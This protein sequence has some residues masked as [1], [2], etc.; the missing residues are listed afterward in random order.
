M[1]DLL[2]T[3]QVLDLLK[4]NR[5][6][7][8]RMLQDGRLKGVKIGQQ[9]R[10]LRGA[11]E[12]LV[13]REPQE[14]GSS[15]QPGAVPSFPTH[16]V[17]T[18]QDLFSG[19]GELSARVVDGAGEPLTQVSQPCRFCELIS[20]SAS[21]QRACQASWQALTCQADPAEKV[22][23]CHAGLQYVC[24][25]LHSGSQLVGWFLVGQFYWEAPKLPEQAAHL[26]RLAATHGLDER[27]LEQAAATIPCIPAAKQVRLKT[28]P[29]AAARAVHSIMNER[30]AFTDRLQQ[31]ANLTQFS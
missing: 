31:I 14:E 25:G 16:C 20:A 11:V 21:G 7:V 19:V 27:A 13:N 6:T 3:Q 24:A 5:I 4:I 9:W 2:T 26:K 18:L 1:D 28:W 10:F 12:R 15:L 22:F 29:A 17:Q 30:V 8:Y 23:T